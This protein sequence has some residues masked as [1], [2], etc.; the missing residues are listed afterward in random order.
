MKALLL[1][2]VVFVTSPMS[3]HLARL[4]AAIVV[5]LLVG[6]AWAL[7]SGQRTRT[8]IDAVAFIFLLFSAINGV[9]S[10]LS[11][12]PWRE[13]LNELMPVAEV[14]FCFGLVSRIGWDE[15]K[16][17]KFLRVVLIS[18]C[19]RAAWQLLL[20][21]TGYFIIPPIY[22]PDDKL[23]A[24]VSIG[25]F[26]YVRLIDPICGMF[27]ALSLVLYFS[28][29]QPR[30]AAIT[31][32]M[33]G[34][35]SVLG[36]TRSEWL[37]TLSV[38]CL[39]LWFGRKQKFVRGIVLA[40]AGG[41]AAV[42]MLLLVSPDFSEFAE[43]RFVSHTIQQV[44]DQ[45][46]ELAE[47]RVL[48]V[49]SSLEKFREAPL[50]GHGLGSEFGTVIDT[51]SELQFITLHNYYLNWMAT[52]GVVG[53]ILFGWMIYAASRL[54]VAL[55]RGSK[56]DLSRALSLC[57]MGSLLWW[58]IFMAFNAIYS[59]Y[60]VTVIIGSAY[61]LAVALV[62]PHERQVLVPASGGTSAANAAR[63]SLIPESL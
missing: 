48:E 32:S 19:V 4:P 41:F 58:G 30:L 7:Q 25:N 43:Q 38:L 2:L 45:G 15:A 40:G 54:S 22:P 1:I 10:G 37:A 13:V 17:G 16:A 51:G 63:S 14:Y 57:A 61:G 5:L 35:V 8:T 11:G 20:T 52:T 18:V 46:N 29:I 26:T 9:V 49:Y 50:F 36:L 62:V 28:G 23:H 44:S 6:G 21:F 31:A 55:V 47:L 42:C 34:L 27:F 59:A 24:L 56:T 12:N 3:L 53:M 60:H 33:C 39:S